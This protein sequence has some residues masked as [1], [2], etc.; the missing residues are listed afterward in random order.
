MEFKEAFAGFKDWLLGGEDYGNN[1]VDDTIEPETDVVEDTTVIDSVDTIIDEIPTNGYE[2]F[3]SMSNNTYVQP[4]APVATAT[5]TQV[6]QQ[7]IATVIMLSPYDIRT[8]QV[9]V[10]HIRNGHIVICNLTASSNNQRVVDYISGGI[11]AFDGQ[12]EPTAV[13][14]TFVCTPKNVKLQ[15]GEN[16]AVSTAKVSAL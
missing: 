13:K 7:P 8:S 5:T 15:V 12:I 16:D 9:V 11:Y 1:Y 6:Y 10:D 4:A 2:E 14:T 3:G